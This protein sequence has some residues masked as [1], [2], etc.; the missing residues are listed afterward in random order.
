MAG[1]GFFQNHLNPTR[2]R[3]NW[4][5]KIMNGPIGK[6]VSTIEKYQK[7]RKVAGVGDTLAILVNADPDALASALA[8]KRLF[9]HK[10]KPVTIFRTNR[11]DHADNLAFVKQIAVVHMGAVQKPDTL[12]QVADFFLKMAD[13]TWS[14]TSGIYDHRLIIIFRNAGFW[15]NAWKMARKLFGEVG[16]AGGHTHSARAE[17]PLGKN[18][19]RVRQRQGLPS[20]CFEA[21]PQNVRGA[22]H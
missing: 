8:F 22:D 11:I 2:Q 13:A 10:V 17:I 16:S 7:L 20:L 3:L 1:D 6:S 4:H 19:L 12:V 21:N 15:R 9:W 18:R 14:I 5:D